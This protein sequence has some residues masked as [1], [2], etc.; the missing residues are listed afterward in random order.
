MEMVELEVTITLQQQQLLFVYSIKKN[1]EI[2]RKILRFW[3][4]NNNQK[5]TLVSWKY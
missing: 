2:N 5:Q 4:K 3:N 1:L